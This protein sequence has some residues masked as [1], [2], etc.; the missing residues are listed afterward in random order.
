MTKNRKKLSKYEINKLLWKILLNL[1]TI[2]VLTVIL[3]DFFN[4]NQ[5]NG[6]TGVVLA[7]YVAIL[8]IYVA[9]K[10]IDRWTR[11][12]Y[13]KYF[14]EF[15]VVIWTI[16]MIIL[17]IANILNPNY[18]LGTEITATYISVLGVYAITQKS[19]NIKQNKK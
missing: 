17:V 6:T 10:E 14:G 13:S 1:W 4:L 7:I 5:Y 9:D 15:F 2:I 19:K 11:K 8:G 3:L 18:K 12:F 16:L